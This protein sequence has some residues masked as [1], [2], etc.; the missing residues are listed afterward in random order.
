M[1]DMG[2]F[3]NK[4]T[5]AGVETDSDVYW[6]LSS[7]FV[8]LSSWNLSPDEMKYALSFISEYGL[9]QLDNTPLIPD[10]A[11]AEFDYGNARVGEFIKVKEDAYDSPTGFV[12]NGRLG[13]L[14]DVSGRR[15]LV[16]Y[17]TDPDAGTTHRHPIG[18]LL[19]L[20]YMVKSKFTPNSKDGSN[21]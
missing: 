11:W 3:R 15:G 1:L 14:V 6:A 9:T 7:A 20:K 16:K 12:H 10:E 19:S 5:N 2:D 17:I 18:K 21:A 4:M 13:L 8:A